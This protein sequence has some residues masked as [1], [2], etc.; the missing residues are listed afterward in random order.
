MKIFIQFESIYLG[1]VPNSDKLCALPGDSKDLV[2]ET[3]TIIELH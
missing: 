3:S 1:T 2:R